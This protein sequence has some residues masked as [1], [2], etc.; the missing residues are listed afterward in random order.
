MATGKKNTQSALK[1]Q[2][3]RA[4]QQQQSF[5]PD[6][7]PKLR[8]AINR[9]GLPTIIRRRDAAE[10]RHR[11]ALGKRVDALLRPI[12]FTLEEGLSPDLHLRA[13][14]REECWSDTREEHFEIERGIR[15]VGLLLDSMARGARGTIDE[16]AV[17][18]LAVVLGRYADATAKLEERRLAEKLREKFLSEEEARPR[19][20]P[21]RKAPAA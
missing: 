21:R 15:A 20:Q 8:S 11:K 1:S 14:V 13:F 7:D 9:S 2:H 10:L 19:L 16:T 6:L 5:D 12:R 18:G 4:S 17:I 3:I